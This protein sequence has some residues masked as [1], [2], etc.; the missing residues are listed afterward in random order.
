MILERT[1]I[2]KESRFLL[3]N[4]GSGA[5]LWFI[6][7]Y[8]S[9]MCCTF[10][11]GLFSIFDNRHDWLFIGKHTFQNQKL[12]IRLITMHNIEF[13]SLPIFWNFESCHGW[14]LEDKW[15]LKLIWYSIYINMNHMSEIVTF[16]LS[17][18]SVL[19][20]N[21]ISSLQI[22]SWTNQVTKDLHFKNLFK[23]CLLL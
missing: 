5:T 10:V 9:Q 13:Q 3:S 19:I 7:K 4:K 21:S 12:A 1:C 16:Y 6:K 17:N 20:G 15:H 14:P 22:T 23:K 11:L 2:S 18:L 8:P